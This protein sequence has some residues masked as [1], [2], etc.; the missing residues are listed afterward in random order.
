LHIF[1]KA[2]I[3]CKFLLPDWHHA[4]VLCVRSE[5]LQ[6]HGCS[7]SIHTDVGGRI[8]A[9]NTAAHL[10]S[11]RTASRQ[12]TPIAFTFGHLYCFTVTVCL[13][14]DGHD[15]EDE[16]DTDEGAMPL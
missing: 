3:N 4:Q 12:L 15:N 5:I 1:K 9:D 10:Y 14:L 8:Q 7:V 13:Q 16:A 2:N 6:K 11:T